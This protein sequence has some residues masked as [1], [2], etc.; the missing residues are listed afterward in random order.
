[1]HFEKQNNEKDRKYTSNLF[2]GFKLE[3]AVR[4]SSNVLKKE[5]NELN[6]CFEE[7]KK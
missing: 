2:C 4:I 1:M 6:N 3:Y 7:E 5:K